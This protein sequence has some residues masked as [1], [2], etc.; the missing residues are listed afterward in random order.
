MEKK[1]EKEKEVPLIDKWGRT[2]KHL[3]TNKDKITDQVKTAEK[4]FPLL[5][6]A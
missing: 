3:L 1:P 5:T 4:T 6:P 2:I